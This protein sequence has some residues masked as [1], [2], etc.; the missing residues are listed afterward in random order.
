M[1]TVQPDQGG[2]RISPGLTLNLSSNNP[3]RNRAA[4]PA[5]S[6]HSAPSPLDP[7]P[8]PVSRNPFLDP[9]AK[10]NSFLQSP[11]KLVF[12]MDSKEPRRPA[13]TGNAAELFDNLTLEDKPAPSRLGPP[14][15]SNTDKSENIRPR[16]PPGH[17]PTRSQ[18]EAMRARKAAGGH[19]PRPE[20]KEELDIFAD[21]SDSPKRSDPSRRPRRNSDSSIADAKKLD[22]E[23]EKK[24]QER[25]RRE[26]EKR[27]AERAKG[28]RP[29]NLD[30][31]D[32]LD[33]TSIYGTGLF[34]HD[35]PFDACN[36]SR[37][38]AG[39]RR[40]PMSAFAK[41]S[42]NNTLGGSG[43]LQKRPDHATFMGNHDDEA[44]IDYA[45]GVPDGHGYDSYGSGGRRTEA[46]VVDSFARVEPIH[47]EESLGLGT[48]TFLE[49]TPASR[50]AMQ[51]TESEQAV[52]SQDNGLSRKKS[53]AQKIRGIS[54][55]RRDY[56]PSGRVTSP[57][58]VYT[59]PTSP[60]VP[61]YI[62]GGPNTIKSNE[63]NP[64]AA[65]FSKEQGSISPQRPLGERLERRVTN[66]GIS[67]P[68][69]PAPKAGGGF[70]TRMKSL[71]GGPRKVRPDV[72]IP[73]QP[74]AL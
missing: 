44:F 12:G 56:G 38:K 3:F 68:E 69:Q 11:D 60:E 33:V 53:L 9:A 71:K 54:N 1:S 5:F 65:E 13:L 4:S 47:G 46:R 29:K 35:G 26:R 34:H 17:R 55:N 18:E 51:R 37:N 73:A 45:K 48:S 20:K 63:R 67:A 8:R 15:R 72:K 21:P 22:P 52:T 10:T 23:E 2:S 25:R 6:N 14:I 31:I 7:P 32:K 64:F 50:S 30:V 62:P 24:R 16:G 28:K 61:T 49:G 43:P 40:A 42:L 27:H 59:S 41:D 57:D 36:P 58:G 70:L 74:Q 39:S 66:D 19:R